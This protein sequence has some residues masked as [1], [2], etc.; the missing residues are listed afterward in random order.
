LS[1]TGIASAADGS[2]VVRGSG[3]TI[4]T[5]SGV[6]LNVSNTA[7]GDN[8]LTFQSIASNGA[9]NGIVLANTSN[10]SGKLIVAGNGGTC[11]TSANCTGGAIQS[12]T[13]AGIDLSSVP[14]GVDLTRMYV[15]A[16]G[17]DGIRAATVAGFAM[18]NSVVT[19]NGNAAGERGLD[20]TQLSGTVTLNTDTV[21]GSYDRNV[22]VDNTS[23]SVDMAVTDGT[24]SL[25]T[26]NYGI[27]MRASGSSA[28]TQKLNIQGTTV[29]GVT[30]N[31]N[32]GNAIVVQGDNNANANQTVTVNNASVS[33]TP[34]AVV[35]GGITM[36]PGGTSTMT[37]TITNNTIVGAN[38][39]A[40]TVDGPGT[41][42]APQPVTIHAT[43]TGNT[44]GNPAVSNSGAFSGNGIGINANGNATIFA[45]VQNNL[46]R[47]YANVAGIVLTVNDGSNPFLN[48]LDATIKS[49][50]INTPGTPSARNGLRADVGFASSG[51]AGTLCLDAGDPSNPA[52]KNN[53]FAGSPDDTAAGKQDIRITE[54]ADAA[55]NLT[56]KL[57]GLSPA[58]PASLGAIAT[59][60]IDR[61]D[62]G[63]TPT[64]AA[65]GALGDYQAGTCTLP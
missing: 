64:A 19:G 54:D 38:V 49:N 51:E 41:M 55:S 17:D 50:T 16:G 1:A 8:D 33:S 47:Q 3:N 37:T 11:T 43:I 22:S 57:P 12:S 46:I 62:A 56:V 29:G 39:Q 4:D 45:L 58:P 52:L 21:S 60:L 24:Y 10:A 15:G 18:A 28:Q 59:Y 34:G 23:G 61:N 31:G 32:N 2:V 7:I 63:G 25:A 36:S 53:V 14:G 30:F 13:S 40:I 5:T 48:R 65:T 9:A 6:A 42:A 35:G 44:I 26:T 20:M 27:F